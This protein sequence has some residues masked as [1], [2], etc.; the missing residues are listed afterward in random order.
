MIDLANN[1]AR[2]LALLHRHMMKLL[3]RALAPLDLGH[4][5]YLYLFRLYNSDGSKQQELADIIGADKAAATRALSRLEEAGLV[6]R[7]ADQQ[8]RRAMRVYLTPR[9]RALR[10]QLEDALANSIASFTGM[11][12][13]GEREQLRNLLAKVASPLAPRP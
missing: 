3:D 1:E 6:R 10:P 4:G 13:T 8:D 5:R 12:D 11:L 2:D 9:G 7:E